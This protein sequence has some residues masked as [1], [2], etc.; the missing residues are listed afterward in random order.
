LICK[1]CLI[2][3]DRKTNKIFVNID[4]C[5]ISKMAK[6]QYHFTLAEI[7]DINK[8]LIYVAY[9]SGTADEAIEDFMHRVYED[10]QYNNTGDNASISTKYGNLFSFTTRKTSMGPVNARYV[11]FQTGRYGLVGFGRRVLFDQTKLLE[12]AREADE[13]PRT[14]HAVPVKII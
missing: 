4:T 7:K 2:K 6:P 9:I 13:R 10:L 14:I 1:V 5:S 12:L 8:E 11:H 3:I